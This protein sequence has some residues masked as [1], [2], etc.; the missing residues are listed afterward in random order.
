[1][2]ADARTLD[3]LLARHA[4]RMEARAARTRELQ[5]AALEASTN[6]TTNVDERASNLSAKASEI[7]ETL[8]GATLTPRERRA[9]RTISP[10]QVGGGAHLD[11]AVGRLDSALTHAGEEIDKRYAYL[12]ALDKRSSENLLPAGNAIGATYQVG[13]FLYSIEGASNAGH[14]IH[15][16]GFIGGFALT[17]GLTFGIALYRIRRGLPSSLAPP[18]SPSE[19]ATS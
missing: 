17:L 4:E 18:K 5:A 10:K 2:A 9:K 12:K 8:A 3:G 6:L 1:M 15:L 7:S 11:A 14:E 19:A 16:A 13:A